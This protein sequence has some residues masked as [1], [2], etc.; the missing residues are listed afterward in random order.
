MSEVEKEEFVVIDQEVDI[1]RS[2]ELR[3]TSI[4]VG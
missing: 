4:I 1:G 3:Q 2:S